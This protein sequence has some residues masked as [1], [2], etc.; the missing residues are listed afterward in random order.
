MRIALD[1]M[2]GDHAPERPVAGALAALD[3]PEGDLGIVLVGDERRLAPLAHADANADRLTIRHAPDIIGMDEAPA[4]ALRRK[5]HSS[6]LVGIELQKSGEADAFV[7]AG[8]TG[9]VMA[10]ALTTLGR[11]EGISRPAIV[12]P[13]P[14]RASPCLVLDV[15][16]N[17]ECKP[18]H[19]AQFALMGHVYAA[20]VLARE[21]PR[22]GLLSIG[23]ESGKGNEL[24]IAAHRLLADSGLNF[25]GNVEGRDVLGGAVDVVV[26]D[27]FTGNVLLKFGESFVD[28]LAGEIEREAGASRRAAL[29]AWLMRPTF[30]KLVR[31]I[32]YAEYGGAPLLGVDGIVIICHG[33]SSVKAFRSAIG[34]ARRGVECDLARR[35]ERAIGSQDHG[36]A[37]R[38]A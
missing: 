4:A 1:A 8:N 21:R 35:I 29:G 9:A 31:R 19:L 20:E 5:R 14:T 25:V 18:H 12:T 30:R 27:G 34:V 24:T 7:S 6:I 37:S 2:G 15:G 32:D 11:I 33:G 3:A 28:F 22:V 17:A 13:F 36:K 26:T 10:A 38:G 23:E 16:A